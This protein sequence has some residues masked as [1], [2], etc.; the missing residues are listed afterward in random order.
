MF[1]QRLLYLRGYDG[2]HDP[3]EIIWEDLFEIRSLPGLLLWKRNGMNGYLKSCT[4]CSFGTIPT[5]DAVIS[6][7]RTT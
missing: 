2:I 6:A 5:K 1:R 4:I 3:K 7:F